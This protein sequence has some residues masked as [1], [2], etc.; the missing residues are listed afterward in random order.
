MWTM[1]TNR[2]KGLAAGAAVG[3]LS[4][5]LVVPALAQDDDT[6]GVETTSET[7]ADHRAEREAEFVAALAAE[8]DLDEDTV[9]EAVS[10]VREQLRTEHRAERRAALEERLAAAVEAGELTQEQ[11]DALLA[12]HDADLL[13]PGRGLRGHP[14]GGRQGGFGRFGG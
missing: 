6:T 5:A 2:A 9:A 13:R 7:F 10:T 11:S 8:L 4:L 1:M 14:G 3:V 12:A